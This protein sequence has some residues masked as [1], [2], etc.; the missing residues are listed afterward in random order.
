MFRKLY[1]SPFGYLISGFLHLFSKIHK[2]FMVY[3]YRNSKTGKFQKLT[4]INSTTKLLN[5]KNIDMADNI[6][7]GHY[8][9][10]DGT[11]G[12]TLGEGVQCLP[13]PLS[14]PTAARMLSGFTENIS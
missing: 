2:P 14:V 1:L 4:R 11:G 8:C 13:I 9:L 3:G 5:K 7:I 6:W 10:V 12:I